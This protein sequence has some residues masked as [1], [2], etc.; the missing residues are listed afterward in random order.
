M[1]ITD[2][3]IYRSARV[4]IDQHGEDAP[5]WAAQKANTMLERGN[6]DGERLWLRILEAI[7]TLQATE[8]PDG[9]VV[10]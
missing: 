4:L 10:Q 3:D 8:P 6:M 7:D 9:A 2:L 1:T 5:I